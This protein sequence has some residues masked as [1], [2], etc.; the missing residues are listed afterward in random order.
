MSSY[1]MHCRLSHRLS[2][3]CCFEDLSQHHILSFVQ[4]SISSIK[5]WC[6]INCKC[7]KNLKWSHISMMF[8]T[9]NMRI[10]I[11][12]VEDGRTFFFVLLPIYILPLQFREY[13]ILHLWEY[14]KRHETHFPL[15][16]F[17][18]LYY[19]VVYFFFP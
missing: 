19:F 3:F 10:E 6:W 8:H 17:F 2:L 5:S 12:I 18:F 9:Y 16:F 13:F 1:K 11:E 4:F 15:H 14:K 7:V